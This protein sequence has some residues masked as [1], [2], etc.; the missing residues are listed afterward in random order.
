MEEIAT[1]VIRVR[2]EDV[3]RAKSRLSD[4]GVVSRETEGAVGKLTAAW[5]GLTGV[6]AA[7]GVTAGA[8]AALTKLRDVATQ[9]ESLEAQLKTATGSAENAQKAFAA[10]QDFATQTP[11]DLAQSTEAFIKLVNLG[12]TPSERALRSYGNTASAMGKDLSAMVQA[13]ANAT[14]GEF[15]MLKQFGVK[16]RTEVDGISFSFR[17]VTTKVRNDARSIEEYFIHLGETNFSGAMLERMATLEGKISNLGDAWDVMFAQIAK[18]GAGSLMKEAIDIATDA[19]Q[20]FTDTLASGQLGG[21]VDALLFKFESLADGVHAAFYALSVIID[22]AFKYWTS[23]GKSAVD[24]LIGMFRDMPE[25]IRAYM[26]V[27]GA[28]LGALVGYAEAV[29]KGVYD[30]IAGWLEYLVTTARNVAKEIAD[31]L[32]HPF[33]PGQFNYVEA[34]AEAFEKFSIRA[35]GSFD[36][37]KSSL[38]T[39]TD[40]F[41]EEVTA[42]MNERDASLAA[43][44][45]KIKSADRLRAAYDKLKASQKAAGEGQD[46]L[47][48]FRVGGR[49]A[50]AEFEHLR[51]RLASQAQL[52]KNSYDKRKTLIME[53]TDEEGS[54]RYEML[55]QLDKQYA[56]EKR[57]L[58]D[59]VGVDLEVK[60]TAIEDANAVELAL[61]KQGFDDKQRALDEF[62][63]A[64]AMAQEEY[65][66]RS[67]Q[68]TQRRLMAEDKMTLAH[69]TDA[70]AK[71]LQNYAIVLGMAATIAQNMEAMA[72]KGSDSAKALF[73]ASKAIAIAQAIVNTEV[74]ATKALEEG[75][76]IFG[77]PAAAVIKA[78]GY[79][80]VATIA[81]Q[82]IVEARGFANGGIVPGSSYSGD[83]VP[84]NVNSGEMILNHRQQRSLWEMANGAG[85]GSGETNVY[86]NV[87]NTVSGAEVTTQE[88]ATPDGKVIDVI[89][90]RAADT[91]AK[92]IRGMIPGPVRGALQAQGVRLG[93]A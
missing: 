31:Q 79:A 68:L 19:I 65:D 77:M 12:L 89:V 38:D 40:A 81:A 7:V 64:G 17:G 56:D 76:L 71:E 78:M 74:A 53:N 4:L 75:G 90:K 70:R 51:D 2:S 84:V 60:K 1:L 50:T 35:V 36:Q 47:A 34:Q 46:R 22:D 85:G 14:T 72:Q 32:K 5:K 92:D 42:I 18:S 62:Y 20:E 45:A 39:V 59:K 80:S 29:G 52:I 44:D 37:V 93:A 83:R 82:S 6:L 88:R 55:N 48:E 33:S 9:F 13:V 43:F 25:N 91:V 41:E 15:E 26:Q 21:Y 66:R 69:V 87:T 28:R 63:D 27:T 58:L 11:Y 73:Y 61:L 30:T 54:L 23:D 24:F 3:D 10:I 67:L 57:A 16:S 49:S 8:M 86:V